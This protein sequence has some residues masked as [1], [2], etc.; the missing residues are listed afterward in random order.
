[1][2]QDR[3][4]AGPA[5]T[6]AFSAPYNQPEPMMEPTEAHMSPISP[7]SRRRPSLSM[8]PGASHRELGEFGEQEAS[9]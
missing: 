2:S 5:A 3:I 7:T 1:M 8:N 9:D 6:T 4:A